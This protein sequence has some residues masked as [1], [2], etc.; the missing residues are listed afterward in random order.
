[1]FKKRKAYKEKLKRLYSSLENKETAMYACYSDND[2]DELRRKVN[3]TLSTLFQLNNAKAIMKK[4][5]DEI[6]Q[7]GRLNGIANAFSHIIYCNDGKW[8]SLETKLP[9][10]DEDVLVLSGKDM[11]VMALRNKYEDGTIYL[12]WQNQNQ[13][14]TL[15]MWEVDY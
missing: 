6:F 2:I 9:V 10:L 1:M 8:I 7:L 13:D 3:T 5:K 11:Y 15:D 14:R 4:S 12:E